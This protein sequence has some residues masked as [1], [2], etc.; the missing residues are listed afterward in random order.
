[1][2]SRFRS[3]SFFKN[4]ITIPTWSFSGCISLKNVSLPQSIQE[5]KDGAFYNCK[6]LDKVELYENVKYIAGNAF[7]GCDRL[8][9]YG[10]KG[11]YAEQYANKHNIPFEEL[12]ETINTTN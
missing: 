7:E 6:S 4:C 1:M 5:I 2:M 3:S 8:T 9:I 11:S 12:D 10:V